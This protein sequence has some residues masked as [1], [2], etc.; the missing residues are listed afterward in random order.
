MY[1]QETA[2]R[3]ASVPPGTFDIVDTSEWQQEAFWS[4]GPPAFQPV[5]VENPGGG[6]IRDKRDPARA[7]TVVVDGYR[8]RRVRLHHLAAKAWRAMVD[9]ARAAGIAEPLLLP[10]SGYRSTARQRKLFASAV[11]KYGSERKARRWVAKPGGSAHHSGRAIDL[12]LGYRI[13]SKYV[14]Q[15]RKTTA[16]QWL[17][18]NA[19]RFGFYPYDAEP[20]HWEYN[21]PMSSVSSGSASTAA[22]RATRGLSSFLT[23]ALS[24]GTE[25]ARTAA[26]IANGN[27]DENSL[28]S[29]LFYARHPERNRRKIG[30][31]ERQAAAEWRQIRDKIVRPLLASTPQTGATVSAGAGSASAS[32]PATTSTNVSF[33]TGGWGGWKGLS[34]TP[35]LARIRP[36]SVAGPL[37][38]AVAATSGVEGAYDKVQTYDRGILSW[39]IKQWTLHAGSLQKLLGFIQRRLVERGRPDLWARLFPGMSIRNGKELWVDGKP[40]VG[41]TKLMRLIRNSTS[42][43]GYDRPHLERWMRL[44]VIAGRNPIIQEL[45]M[46]HA[47]NSLSAALNKNPR[48][49]FKRSNGKWGFKRMSGTRRVGDY[50][51]NDGRAI[52]LFQSMYT[53]LPAWALTYV[54]NVV[55][56]MRSRFGAE[57]EW[58]GG[59]Q[60]EFRQTFEEEFRQSGVACWGLRAKR[61]KSRCRSRTTRYDK[62]VASLR[63]F[64]TGP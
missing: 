53:Q 31:S 54:G 32:A 62:T 24:R 47:K 57:S 55:K 7:D 8:G 20:W 21:P 25:I 12:Y 26:A 30:R 50:L 13:S 17:R 42:K 49:A 39:G 45:Q 44:F 14:R 23:S 18:D 56:K 35:S 3:S 28:T 27:R 58:P 33:K 38:V 6:R 40:Y 63:R 5:A 1:T 29:E 15:M 16:W 2:T 41:Q 36:G 19:E 59:W 37:A 22:V 61:G 60:N 9:A 51:G 52:A 48:Q 11:K 34:S 46:E 10:V 4:F 43:T 64:T